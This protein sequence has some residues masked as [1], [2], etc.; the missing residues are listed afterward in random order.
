MQELEKW[1][2]ED[3]ERLRKVR[4]GDIQQIMK[5]RNELES[6]LAQNRSPKTD[7]EKTMA[8]KANQEIQLLQEEQ[9]RLETSPDNYQNPLSLLRRFRNYDPSPP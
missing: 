7:G 8:Q 6:Y 9:K 1:R 4:Q 5:R 3:Q 2:K